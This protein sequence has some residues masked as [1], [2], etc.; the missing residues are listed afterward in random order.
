M[1]ERK[2]IFDYLA[3][4]M[5][6][7]GFAI[8]FMAV[9]IRILGNNVSERESIFFLQGNLSVPIN[10]I[11]QLFLLSIV[12]TLLD[13]LTMTDCIIKKLSVIKR[14][15]LMVLSI[16]GAS[17]LFIVVFNWFPIDKWKC[18]SV[19]LI[20]F[21]ICFIV[22]VAVT[23]IKDNLENKKLEEGLV[24]FQRKWEEDNES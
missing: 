9:V 10:I 1:N 24:K 21:M 6:I 3:Q 23:M 22:S 12:I 19:F 17:S 15:I 7:F 18:W 2:T 14:T 5:C 11:F 13:Y 16:L 4:V 20:C 8:L